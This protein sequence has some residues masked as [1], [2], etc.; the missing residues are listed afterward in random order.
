MDTVMADE[1]GK[2]QGA[3]VER[4]QKDSAAAGARSR[5]AAADVSIS[6]VHV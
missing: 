6:A 4:S 2:G 1:L 5:W 3:A